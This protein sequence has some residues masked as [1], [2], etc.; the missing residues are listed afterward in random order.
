MTSSTSATAPMT[1]ILTNFSSDASARGIV[2]ILMQEKIITSVNIFQHH[3]T[4]Y[5][6]EGQ[7]HERD[8]ASA[9]FKTSVE[10]K[11]RLIKRL[12]ELHP[13]DVPSIVSFDSSSIAEYAAWLGAPDGYKTSNK[14]D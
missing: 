10:N 2:R 8:E 7:I 1:C 9:I 12:K 4:I 3:L 11:M 6:W 13:Y 14:E 5:P